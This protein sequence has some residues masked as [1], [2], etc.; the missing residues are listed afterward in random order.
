MF[1]K[2]FSLLIKMLPTS[3][4]TKQQYYND[5]DF[6]ADVEFPDIYESQSLTKPGGSAEESNIWINRNHRTPEQQREK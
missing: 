5:S 2:H 1:W 3:G 6:W 4:L